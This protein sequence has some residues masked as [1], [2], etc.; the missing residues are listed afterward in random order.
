M[1]V[2]LTRDGVPLLTG[3]PL[4]EGLTAEGASAVAGIVRNLPGGIAVL[5]G[6]VVS[7]ERMQPGHWSGASACWG[8]ENREAAVRLL[9]ANNGN[10]TARTSRSSAWTPAPTATS[11]P[12]W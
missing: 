10:P 12:A 4:A 3:G 7:G 1:H 9:L 5:A 6:T 8:V 11:R 2:S